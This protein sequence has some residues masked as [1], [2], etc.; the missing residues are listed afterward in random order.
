MKGAQKLEYWLMEADPCTFYVTLLHTQKRTHLHYLIDEL[1]CRCVPCF[2][3]GS[4]SEVPIATA[5]SIEEQI[6]VGD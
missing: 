4:Q 6:T 2:W 1:T 3:N 5:T